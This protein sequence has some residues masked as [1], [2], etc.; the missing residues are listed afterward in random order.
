MP[1]QNREVFVTDLFAVIVVAAIEEKL[2][3]PGIAEHKVVAYL[4]RSEDA[5]LCE[6]VMVRFDQF[7]GNILIRKL[8]RPMNRWKD[9][10][11]GD[12]RRNEPTCARHLRRELFG[13]LSEH[14]NDGGLGSA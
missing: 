2:L 11:H 7:Y 13:D 4:I 1:T 12:C 3:S 5:A 14:R 10:E 6:Q 8:G 9:G